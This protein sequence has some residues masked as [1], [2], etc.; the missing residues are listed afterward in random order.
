MVPAPS[1]VG[2]VRSA[3]SKVFALSF[4][5][6][7]MMVRMVP[8]SAPVMSAGSVIGVAPCQGEEEVKRTVGLGC[9]SWEMSGAAAISFTRTSVSSLLMP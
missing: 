2:T 6:L 7:V 8:S 5:Q 9:Y 4:V 1:M 3:G